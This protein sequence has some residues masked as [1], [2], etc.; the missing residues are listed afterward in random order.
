MNSVPN[1]AAIAALIAAVCIG[2]AEGGQS[3]IEIHS[4]HYT[5]QTDL[6]AD[7]ARETALYLERTRAALL[8]AAWP[9]ARPPEDSITAYVLRDDVEFGHLFGQRFAGLF[10][11]S[12]LTPFVLFYGKPSNAGW[13]ARQMAATLKHELTHHLSAYFLLR[14]PRWL[15][16]GIASYLET[17]EISDDGSRAVVGYSNPRRAGPVARAQDIF[18]WTGRDPED[19]DPARLYAGSWLLV[20]WMM[21]RKIE[22]FTEFQRRLDK[23]EEA[24]SAWKMAF[25]MTPDRLNEELILY[26]QHGSYQ[27]LTVRVPAVE[28]PTSQ[29]RLSDAEAHALRARLVLWTLGQFRDES[30]ERRQLAR[31]EVDEALRQDPGNVVALICTSELQ[32]ASSES[33]ARRAVAAHPESAE[34]W[35]MLAE[36]LRSAV[37]S[38]AD[39]DRALEQENALKKATSL[40]AQNA[41]AANSLAWLYV[42]QRRFLAALPLAK[43]AVHLAPWSSPIWDTYAA[44]VFGLKNCDESI[45]AE[46]RALQLLPD[47]TSR[48]A[49]QRYAERLEKY[50][51]SCKA[52]AAQEKAN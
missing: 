18:A 30:L 16:E 23:G 47:G 15:A 3:W 5:L 13:F 52:S 17:I 25:G 40:G 32:P 4:A 12:T 39:Q 14:Q 31:R 43:R 2:P 10:V 19:I 9:H 38:S 49:A 22:Q 33:L 46:S 36:A 34:A 11:R 20:H 26:A 44:V 27:T 7:D 50:Q 21:N 45:A 28:S 6:S 29:R 37:K 51:S 41:V 42:G 1:S 24:T 35:L 8:A 48:S